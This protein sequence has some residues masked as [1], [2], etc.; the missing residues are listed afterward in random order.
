MD[1]PGSTLRLGLAQDAMGKLAPWST[2]EGGDTK[3]PGES[4]G[5]ELRQ[6]AGKV[7][8]SRVSPGGP[9]ALSGLLAVGDEVSAIDGKSLAEWTETGV[10]LQDLTAGEE[11]AAVW[12]E[13]SPTAPPPSA[14]ASTAGQPAPARRLCVL[15]RQKPLDG[16]GYA[17][18]DVSI[19]SALP[20]GAGIAPKLPGRTL[21]PDTHPVPVP[22]LGIEIVLSPEGQVLVSSVAEGGAVWLSA[23]GRLEDAGGLLQ[24]GDQVLAVDGQPLD[25]APATTAAAAASLLKVAALTSGLGGN[26]RLEKLT[27]AA[28][29]LEGSLRGEF[30]RVHV[31]LERDGKLTTAEIVR[32]PVLKAKDLE[33]AAEFQR[34]VAS[35]PPV[36]PSARFK[37]REGRQ[38]CPKLTHIRPAGKD[39]GWGM[40]A[41]EAAAVISAVLPAPSAPPPPPGYVSVSAPSGDGNPAAADV[42]GGGGGAGGER[43]GRG[44]AVVELR[45][46]DM[47]LTD[48]ERV[49]AASLLCAV[50]E[51]K[52]T[53]LRRRRRRGV[54]DPGAH[55][56]GSGGGGAVST[57]AGAKVA[58]L[59]AVSSVIGKGGMAL[60]SMG[61]WSS[62]KMPDM[63]VK[64]PEMSMPSLFGKAKNAGKAK[65]A[66]SAVSSSGSTTNKVGADNKMDKKDDATGIGGAG[67]GKEEG[68]Y[69]RPLSED[70]AAFSLQELGADGCS[71]L[72]VRVMEAI[73]RADVSGNSFV[74]FLLRC[75]FGEQEWTLEKRFSN[76]CAL[77]EQLVAMLGRD[78]AAQL[79]ALPP[80]L[81]NILGPGACEVQ[82]RRHR[83]D[84]YMQELC[85]MA[86]SGPHQ[87]TDA[88]AGDDAAHKSV[89]HILHELYRFVEFVEHVVP[90]GQVGGGLA[91][92]AWAQDFIDELFVSLHISG[93][94]KREEVE[95]TY[96]KHGGS[97][98]ELAAAFVR[99][100]H[101]HAAS[102][103]R[104]S[105]HDRVFPDGDRDVDRDRD[106]G[107]RVRDGGDMD[108]G[109]KTKTAEESAEA[110]AKETKE[111][112]RSVNFSELFAQEDEKE[113]KDAAAE[114]KE[115]AVVEGKEDAAAEGKE[116]AA[117]EGKEDAAAEG[118]ETEEASIRTEEFFR[119][120]SFS[121]LFAAQE[122]KKEEEKA[123]ANGKE[124]DATK[125]RANAIET[126][127]EAQAETK[128]VT[129][130]ETKTVTR[131]TEGEAEAAAKAATGQASNIE[132]ETAKEEMGACA[133]AKPAACKKEEGGEKEEALA[134]ADRAAA[135]EKELALVEAERRAAVGG[136]EWSL[137][138]LLLSTAVQSA[139]YDARARAA[140]RRL[141][142]ELGVPWQAL[143]LK[144]TLLIVT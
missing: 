101:S 139:R 97:T 111:F 107:D 95:A 68:K 85:R 104:Q 118:K 37:R 144:S 17:W 44:V 115:D 132:A 122:E 19:K 35:L 21:R 31:A 39:D 133:Q 128:T 13:I 62:V 126:E 106:R 125:P 83:L 113:D 42:A 16:K 90:G 117:A 84:A 36:P 96:R 82:E 135:V 131:V 45:L 112:F 75:R 124:T 61:S 109:E 143:I 142:R 28:E 59:S 76:F 12:L 4:F 24:V 47:N 49:L 81:A 79:P 89:L 110:A 1:K 65:S 136:V 80:K 23:R 22:S 78:F 134:E 25:W 40:T 91:E 100:A 60:S 103:P 77:H 52:H 120:V 127:G 66:E 140:L 10:S 105:S 137:C 7:H 3:R 108:T 129:Q 141:T 2:A 102:L 54:A 114:G 86:A 8:I 27:R 9:A 123:A 130:A 99:V 15:I 92:Q 46:F 93:E 138:W 55:G 20:W 38:S 119:S 94:V 29:M 121:E 41:E 88:C 43:G 34:R 48:D 26:P 51:A 69:G 70:E 53:K 18:S 6:T 50:L 98:H 67:D 58:P 14:G 11:G 33:A 56:V 5:C 30:S 116:D 73:N 32:A 71:K 87:G 63:N 64:M 72:N 57:S 74:A